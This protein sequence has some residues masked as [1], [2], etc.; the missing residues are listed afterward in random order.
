[1]SELVALV[2][3]GSNAARFFL[4]RIAPG[5]GYR[6]LREERAQTRL[7]GG[8]G[9]L[10]R[11]AISRTVQATRR[12]LTSLPADGHRV[13]AVAT[14]AVRDA[15]NAPRLVKALRRST[16]IE[17]EVL[18]GEAEARLGA[19]A[20]LGSLPVRSG[21][22][23]DVGGGSAQL[24]RVRRG[25]IEPL[26][27]VPLGVVRMTRRFLRHDPPLERETRA[28]RRDVHAQLASALAGI[29]RVPVV[30]LGGTARALGRIHVKRTSRRPRR[31]VHGLRLE[32]RDVAALRARLASLP[33]RRRRRVPGLKAKRA[34]VIVAGA[35]VIEEIMALVRAPVVT[36]CEHGVRHGVLLRE[37][38]G[39][40]K[41]L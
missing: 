6:I 24:T 16:G 7:A 20:A 30:A 37:T 35:V 15:S 34:D 3:I 8:Q 29:T 13:I 19:L 21:L 22:I 26:A 36:I 9:R 18:S 14:A 41:R 25:A 1:M 39:V 31:T 38:F 4:A 28:L 11:E 5:R 32:T 27:S 23:L 2:D 33:L 12:F 10:P 40:E 17:V